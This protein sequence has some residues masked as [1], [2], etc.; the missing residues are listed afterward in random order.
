MS[1]APMTLWVGRRKEPILSY[2]Q[3]NEK[4]KFGHKRVKE[5]EIF[6]ISLTHL[7]PAS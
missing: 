3:K 4:K 1:V 5:N 7:C 2:V 6:Q